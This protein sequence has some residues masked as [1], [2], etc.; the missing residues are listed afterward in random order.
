MSLADLVRLRLGAASFCLC[1]MMTCSLRASFVFRGQKLGGTRL[2]DLF[3]T[4]TA[5]RRSQ[6]FKGSASDMLMVGFL[7]V[8]F[9]R[10]VFDR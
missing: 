6:A 1:E 5:P 8:Y 2:S 7:L 3:T 4:F 9:N 10:N